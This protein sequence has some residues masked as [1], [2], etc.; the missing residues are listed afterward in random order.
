MIVGIVIGDVL[1]KFFKNY[2]NNMCKPSYPI[3]DEEYLGTEKYNSA[4]DNELASDEIQNN[5]VYQLSYNIIADS[6][7]SPNDYDKYKDVISK[8]NFEILI[9]YDISEKEKSDLSYEE[10]FYKF[11]IFELK[12]T[13]EKAIVSY[14]FQCYKYDKKDCR[15]TKLVTS[16][17]CYNPVR[18]YFAYND[19]KWK[20]DHI[21]DPP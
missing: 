3:S 21:Y 1:N 20:V 17:S 7:N 12:F 8:D 9:P 14:E 11:R 19:G 2:D 10:Y 6:Y 16:D 13:D 5:E 18:I 4:K 15:K